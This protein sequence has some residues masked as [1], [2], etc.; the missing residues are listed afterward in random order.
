M[1]VAVPIMLMVQMAADEIVGMAAVRDRFMSAMG[2][3]RVSLVMLAARMTRRAIGR[4]HAALGDYVFIHV[5]L[6]R[7]VKM[8]LVHVIDMTFV[9]DRSM[10][11]G[12]AMCMRML[13]MRLVIG[14]D[15]SSLGTLDLS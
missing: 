8:P 11:A 9:F 12:G 14:H 5:S 1:I 15:K 13:I 2:P 6:V 7:A 3:V 4:V 10:S